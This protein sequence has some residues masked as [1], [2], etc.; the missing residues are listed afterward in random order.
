MM[1][2]RTKKF[3]NDRA[4]EKL[5]GS[6]VARQAVADEERERRAEREQWIAEKAELRADLTPRI[7]ELR[8]AIDDA[9]LGER[10]AQRLLEE[11]REKREKLQAE[12]FTLSMRLDN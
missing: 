11:R 5:L 9:E 12:M 4:I 2:L 1:F 3:P 6:P 7:V 8:A 10:A